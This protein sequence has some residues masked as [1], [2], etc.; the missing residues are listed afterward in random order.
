MPFSGCK[1]GSVLDVMTHC[2]REAR[3]VFLRIFPRSS[4]A[5]V[6]GVDVVAKEDTCILIWF[7]WFPALVVR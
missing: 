3:C 2:G 4:L 6:S 7:G 1:A 5:V